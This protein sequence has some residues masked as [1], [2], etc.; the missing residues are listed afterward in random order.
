MFRDV[1]YRTLSGWPRTR[2]LLGKGANPRFVVTSLARKRLETQ[3]LY[4]DFYC[5]RGDMENRVKKQ[6]TGPVRGS[7]QR[8][9]LTL[10]GRILPC[11]PDNFGM[12]PIHP[13]LRMSHGLG[14][15]YAF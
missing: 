6:H 1:Q 12:L 15:L 8:G 11:A 4:G 14:F 3:A 7:D 10:H 9:G 2:C 13:R 5:A